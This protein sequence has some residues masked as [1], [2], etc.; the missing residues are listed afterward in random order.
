MLVYQGVSPPKKNVFFFGYPWAA[1]SNLE[2]KP[3]RRPSERLGMGEEP[4]A[5]MENTI[6][7]DVWMGHPC[8]KWRF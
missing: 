5:T 8:T 7:M 1:L 4:A 3:I 6:S 2:G